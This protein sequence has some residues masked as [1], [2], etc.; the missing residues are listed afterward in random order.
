MEVVIPVA[1]A[2]HVIAYGFFVKNDEL[3]QKPWELVD[4]VSR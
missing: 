2:F 4:I 3:Q 1:S